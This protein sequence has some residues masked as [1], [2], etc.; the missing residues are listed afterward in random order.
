MGRSP[1]KKATISRG[2]IIRVHDRMQDG[3]QY[4]LE[5]RAGKDFADGFAPHFSPRKMLELG[6]FEGKSGS[7]R[8]SCLTLPIP[9]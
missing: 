7:R 5:A 1:D 2:R 4:R 8:R 9:A 3:Y 6:I